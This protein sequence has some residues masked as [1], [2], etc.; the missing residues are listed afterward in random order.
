MA[1]RDSERHLPRVGVIAP[2]ATLPRGELQ[3]GLRRFREQGWPVELHPQCLKR[4]RFFAGTDEARAAAFLEFAAD[5]EIDVLWFARGGYGA[6]R[7]LPE[8]S[9]AS[10]VLRKN[11]KTLVGY[12]DATALLN[13]AR[14]QWGW[15]TIHAMM[16][17]GREFSESSQ[18]ELDRALDLVARQNRPA[19]Q[20]LRWI[21]PPEGRRKAEGIRGSVFGGNLTVLASL[22][23]TPY[24]P[25]L[26]G[27]IL[28]LEDVDEA[29]YRI[30][31][32]A[33]Q[34]RLSGVLQ[35]VRAIVLGEFTRCEDRVLQALPKQ[36]ASDSVSYPLTESQ[37]SKWPR[38]PV[39]RLI[40]LASG[41]REI[42]GELGATLRIPVA[43]GL[44]AGHGGGRIPLE[45]G[46]S[47]ELTREGWL[48]G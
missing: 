4:S 16:P 47:Y 36:V 32:Y 46:G 26:K 5:P 9:R 15:R 18:R 2:S 37:L 33:L 1:T 23:G 7:L 25:D 27:S 3:L 21:V 35:G 43:M 45:L 20:K 24:F 30:D 12:S 22:V 41:L 17:G 48:R 19:P 14:Q 28:F 40:P 42:F 10:K 13:V 8:L 34:L 6:A 44:R 38:E 29:L 31:R 39:R 11:P